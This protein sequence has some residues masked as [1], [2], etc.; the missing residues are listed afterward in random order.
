MRKILGIAIVAVLLVASVALW[1]KS[2]VS[3]THSTAL[4]ATGSVP[5]GALSP[6]EMMKSKGK[7]LPLQVIEGDLM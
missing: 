7:D 4:E 3:A 6:N 2:T 1:A 5:A